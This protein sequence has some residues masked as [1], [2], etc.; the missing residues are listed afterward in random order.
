MWASFVSVNMALEEIGCHILPIGG[1]VGIENIMSYLKVFK[2]DG[3]ISIPSILIAVAE[4]VEKNKLT[5]F[6]IKKIGYGGEHLAPAAAEYLKRVL[7]A[8]VIGSA[9]YAINDTGVVAF[10]CNCCSGSV[11]HIVEDLH[12]VEIVDPE[13]YEPLPQENPAILSLPTSTVN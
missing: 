7:G 13:T 3:M 6:S 2:V 5:D 10:Q 11:H 4:Y 12:I 9:S 8:E 1:H